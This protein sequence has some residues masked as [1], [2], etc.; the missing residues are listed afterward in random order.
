M[1]NFLFCCD[2][3]EGEEI[4]SFFVNLANYTMIGVI[5]LFAISANNTMI[6]NLLLIENSKIVLFRLQISFFYKK[7]RES[8]GHLFD[9]VPPYAC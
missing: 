6:S 8:L 3:L 2:C 5:L 4:N 1:L 9:V 7:N